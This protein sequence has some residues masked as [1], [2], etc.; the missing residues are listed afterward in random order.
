MRGGCSPVSWSSEDDRF[1]YAEVRLVTVGLL[2]GGVVVIVST[3]RGDTRHVIS[4]RKAT[5]VERAMT[6]T[7][8]WV[9]PDDAPEL[10]SDWFDA[11]TVKADGKLVN[12]GGRPKGSTTSNR[13]QL[14]L[15]IPE[16][17]LAHFKAGGP[18]WQTRM[19]EALEREAAK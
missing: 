14:T 13:R 3:D 2:H 18:G 19:V 17:V 4:M 12:K 9:D 16:P 8:E 10:R 15:R 6:I 11:A 1:D 7:G 5:K